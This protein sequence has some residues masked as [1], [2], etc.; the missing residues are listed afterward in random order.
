MRPHSKRSWWRSAACQPLQTALGSSSRHPL[1]SSN[2][3]HALHNL[4]VLSIGNSCRSFGGSPS[5]GCLFSD[6][7]A[8]LQQTL[9]NFCE[10]NGA[11]DTLQNTKKMR[12]HSADTMQI[13]KK[14][15]LHRSCTN[16]LFVFG[17]VS[18]SYY[19]VVGAHVFVCFVFCIVSAGCLASMHR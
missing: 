14:T 1:G 2:S 4:I 18:F 16:S 17:R 3:W 13:T 10:K 12:R 8:P 9:V 7:R 15:K 6:L 11:S 5:N 19:A